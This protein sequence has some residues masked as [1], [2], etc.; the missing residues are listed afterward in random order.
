MDRRL[1][2]CDPVGV[3]YGGKP[4]PARGGVTSQP[5]RRDRTGE[6]DSSERCNTLTMG[7]SRYPFHALFSTQAFTGRG[8]AYRAMKF[9]EMRL[10]ARETSLRRLASSISMLAASDLPLRNPWGSGARPEFRS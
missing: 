9:S 3:K 2:I 4:L 1:E 7:L 8:T 5:G 10:R 6:G